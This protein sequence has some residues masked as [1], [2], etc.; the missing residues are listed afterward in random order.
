MEPQAHSIQIH[1]L[2]GMLLVA[3]AWQDAAALSVYVRYAEEDWMRERW[4]S[5]LSFG[6]KWTGRS[7]VECSGDLFTPWYWSCSEASK[8]P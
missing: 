4:W 5:P 8:H 3:V 2:G 6:L 7:V 1:V